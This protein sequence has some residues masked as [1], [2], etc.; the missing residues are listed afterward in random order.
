MTATA[1]CIDEHSH[2]F[3][4]WAASRAAS[5]TGCRFKVKEGL[6]WLEVS[7]LTADMSA[8]SDLPEPSQTDQQHRIWRARICRQ[9]QTTHPSVSHGVAAKLINCYLKSRFV[10]GGHHEHPNVAA[11]HPPI[12]R[13]LLMALAKGSDGDEGN[14]W[15]KAGNK[16]W[17]KFDSDEYEDLIAMM[18]KRLNG[19]P[20]WTIEEQ[21]RGVQ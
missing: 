12:D 8:P 18:R 2:R 21:W 20:L 1:Y 19:A 5:V 14:A 4:A 9:A 16:G 7:G 10:C 3:A 11:L 15:K 17:S 13:L 6:D